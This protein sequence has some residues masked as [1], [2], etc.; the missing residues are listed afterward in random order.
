MRRMTTAKVIDHILLLLVLGVFVD[1]EVNMEE[2][3][4]F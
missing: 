3:E 1:C 4:E 2:A